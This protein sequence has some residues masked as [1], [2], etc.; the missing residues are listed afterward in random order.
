MALTP[1]EKAAGREFEAACLADLA[2][3]NKARP[4]GMGALVVHTVV[5]HECPEKGGTSVGITLRTV[6]R[7]GN[8][9]TA[10]GRFAFMR[11]E[12]R[13]SGC[14]RTVR[15]TDGMFVLLATDQ[16]D[17]ERQA[18]PHPGDP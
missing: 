4:P 9:T 11:K 5:R 10:D 15:T 13:C 8:V 7:L 2:A 6:L 3:L 16:Q 18:G 12:G 1:E 17:H 14:G